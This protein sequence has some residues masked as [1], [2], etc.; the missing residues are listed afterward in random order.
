MT[1][2]TQDRTTR[3]VFSQAAVASVQQLGGTVAVELDG[4]GAVVAATFMSH[5][6]AVRLVRALPERFNTPLSED[7]QAALLAVR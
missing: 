4:G 6:G 2:T 5:G 1:I 7:D 3:A